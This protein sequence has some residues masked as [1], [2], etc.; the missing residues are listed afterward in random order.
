[1]I[2]EINKFIVGNAG[3][4]I[5]ALIKDFSHNFIFSKDKPPSGSKLEKMVAKI[6]VSDI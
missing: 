5:T 1:M 2:E 3:I 4:P 6:K